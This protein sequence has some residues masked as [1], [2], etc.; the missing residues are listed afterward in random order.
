MNTEDLAEPIAGQWNN[1]I[2]KLLAGSV[3]LAYP[4]Y[5]GFIWLT[6]HVLPTADAESAKGVLNAIVS[7]LAATGVGGGTLGLIFRSLKITDGK[8]QKKLNDDRADSIADSVADS[9]AAEAQ[10]TTSSTIEDMK[11]SSSIPIVADFADAPGG[12]NGGETP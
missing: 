1:S 5:L 4:L 10:S 3:I 12:D 11:N 8:I 6:N 2:F 9:R 7:T